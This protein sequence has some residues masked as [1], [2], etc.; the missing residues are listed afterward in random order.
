VLRKLWEK[1][2]LL[3]KLAL[4]ERATP[5]EIFWSLFIGAFAGCTP[6]MGF[7]GIVAVALATLFKKNR[8][9]AWLGA[10]ISNV[11]MLPFI[12]LAEVQVAHRIREGEWLSLDAESVKTTLREEPFELLLDWLIGMWPVGIALG[13][14][15]GG[16]GYLA[17]WIRDRRKARSEATR[18]LAEAPAPSSGSTP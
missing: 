6:A 3:W 11:I 15:C 4:T 12:V 14:L 16:L 2:K 1:A 7:H 5:R 10:R 17:A 18:K 9:F 8:L 13:L